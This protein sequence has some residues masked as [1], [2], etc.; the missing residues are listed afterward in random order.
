MSIK[1]YLQ[2][3]KW[4]FVHRGKVCFAAAPWRPPGKK[5]MLHLCEPRGVILR[6]D[7]L[8]LVVFAYLCVIAFFPLALFVLPP[9]QACFGAVAVLIFVLTILCECHFSFL[10]YLVL[11]ARYIHREES[12]NDRAVAEFVILRKLPRDINTMIQKYY[13]IRYVKNKRFTVNYYLVEKKKK[14]KG[15]SQK[16]FLVLKIT[17]DKVFFNKK[18]IFSE[19]ITDLTVLEDFLREMQKQ[20][21]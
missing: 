3:V 2:F 12:V 16:E 18:E 14:L 10:Y 6:K 1:G 7:R 15:V 4:Y 19:K 21:G 13:S 5:K 8:P 17:S 20:T 11:Y 9:W